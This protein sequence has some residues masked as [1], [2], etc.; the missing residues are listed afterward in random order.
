MM[1]SPY[2]H[3]PLT[4]SASGGDLVTGII[5]KFN[6]LSVVD[7]DEERMRFEREVARLKAALDRSQSARD[8]AESEALT[9]RESIAGLR[10]DTQNRT[11]DLQER[12]AEYEV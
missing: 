5:D 9:L 4:K 3:T 7:K 10:D 12:V 8:E 1:Q 2:R 6:L 11:K